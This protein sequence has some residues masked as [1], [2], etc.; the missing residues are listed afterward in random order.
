MFRNTWVV[1]SSIYERIQDFT[2]DNL[3]LRPLLPVIYGL[4]FTVIKTSSGTL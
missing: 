1:Y 4:V 2:A 3:G